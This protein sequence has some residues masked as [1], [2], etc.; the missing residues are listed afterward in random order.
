ML[1]LRPGAVEYEAIP[2]KVAQ[3]HVGVLSGLVGNYPG[4]QGI[5]RFV[6]PPLVEHFH[7]LGGISPGSV[8]LVGGVEVVGKGYVV[9]TA[10]HEVRPGSVV[11][12]AEAAVVGD[13]GV[14]VG[15]APGVDEDDA[16]TGL[17]S[18]D[19]TGRCILEHGNALY[20]VG[21]HLGEGAFHAVNQHQRAAAVKGHFASDI[22][23]VVGSVNGAAG[24]CEDQGRIGTLDGHGG[25]G[26]R[27][28]VKFLA[29]N[30]GDRS[31]EVDSL[32][33]AVT[34]DHKLIQDVVFTG[35]N[36]CVGLGLLSGKGDFLVVKSKVGHCQHCRERQSLESKCTVGVREGVFSSGLFHQRSTY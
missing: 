15:P 13:F 21:V 20:V 16:R 28:G 3:I 35:Q 22:H 12:D 10:C 31:G 24:S 34:H 29:V 4:T 18:V 33:S 17:C 30:H 1:R 5:F 6:I 32:L 7:L 23:A 36:D 8:T 9:I 26:D 27:T 2:V 14:T 19:G 25:V 11:G